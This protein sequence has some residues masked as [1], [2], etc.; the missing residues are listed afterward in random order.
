[1]KKA[2]IFAVALAW[3]GSTVF[4][5]LSSAEEV[6]S[7]LS[8]A[9]EADSSLSS[10]EEVDS[11][12]SN[13]EEADSSPGSTEEVDNGPEFIKITNGTETSAFPA[14]FPH[15]DHQNRLVDFEDPKGR[16]SCA[17]CHHGKDADNKQVEYAE[18]G[19]PKSRKCHTCH[20]TNDGGISLEGKI[21]GIP[22]LFPLTNPIQRAGHGRCVNCHQG[23]KSTRGTNLLMCTTCHNMYK[24]KIK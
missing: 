11:S 7:S 8:S 21:T 5:S 3:V 23:Q 17:I 19:E 12:P 22:V 9:E 1:M 15:H 13:A 4:S 6:D 14:Y 20:N 2:I 18:A 24:D 16:K 10:T